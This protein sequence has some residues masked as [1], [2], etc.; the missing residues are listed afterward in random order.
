MSPHAG[1]RVGVL[2]VR[3]R[4]G[5]GERECAHAGTVVAHTRARDYGHGRTHGMHIGTV[6]ARQ[7]QGRYCAVR[8]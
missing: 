2:V 6:V 7:N 1:A 3:G 4:V 5:C 8:V